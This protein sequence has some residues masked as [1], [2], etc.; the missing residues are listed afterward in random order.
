MV[1][2]LDVELYV[3][4][5]LGKCLY[6]LVS[7]L[8]FKI[9]SPIQPSPFTIPSLP[10]VLIWRHLWLAKENPLD[11]E[12]EHLGLSPTF[13][14]ALG[15]SKNLSDPWYVYHKLLIIRLLIGLC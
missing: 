1:N 12:S 15:K 13:C 3:S 11:L 9:S 5:P 8:C 14:V 6:L 7:L 4:E 2:K 10:S